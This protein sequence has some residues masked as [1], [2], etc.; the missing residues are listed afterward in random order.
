MRTRSEAEEGAGG[1][2]KAGWRDMAWRGAPRRWATQA[3]IVLGGS[4]DMLF[5]L[6]VVVVEVGGLVEVW[7]MV[8]E[9]Q[10]KGN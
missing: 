3:R 10:E 5:V 8:K 4:V 6:V 1:E 2:G 9:W 7:Q